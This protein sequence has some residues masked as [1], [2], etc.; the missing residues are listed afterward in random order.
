MLLN[1]A[2]VN[3]CDAAVRLLQSGR[4]VE[5]ADAFTNIVVKD[6]KVSLA[7]CNRG[8]ALLQMGDAV[9]AILNIQRAIDIE[10]GVPEF[11]M[12][13]G[14]AYYNL[15]KIDRAI[16]CYR[17]SLELK[18]SI[19]QTHMNLANAIK[20]K[21]N[22]REALKSYR[23]ATEMDP[24]DV[25]CHLNRA[26]AELALGNY[27]EGW[28]E[29]EW[30]WKSHQMPPRGLPLPEWDGSD[31]SGKSILLYGEQ[32]LGDV[33]QFIRYAEVLK[34]NYLNVKVT[35][36]VRYPIT[37]LARKVPGVDAVIAYGEEV[38]VA[39]F[40]CACALLSVPRHMQTTVDTIPWLGAYLF[41]DPARVA[42]WRQRLQ[43]LP[44]GMLVGVCWA[45]QSRPGR[46][47]CEVIDKRRSTTLSAF[48]P[49]AQIPGISWV[50]L[51]KGIPRS[52]VEKP[53]AGMTIG[54]WTDELDDF[55]DTAAL[56][57]CLDLVISVDTSVVHLAAGM[58][59]PTWLLSRWD[60]CWRW[61]DCRQD[62]P[63]Y[64]TLR[65]FVQPAPRD[66]TSMMELA[67]TE[68]R[69]RVAAF[70]LAA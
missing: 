15:E 66:W 7:W 9:D 43:A 8:L 54:D 57:E 36:E 64:P 67:A 65:Q 17:K 40:D 11:H 37:R 2:M 47:E 18:P 41:A 62:S 69:K 68:L 38:P 19:A 60:G 26:H 21:G 55:Y 12:N 30:R 59:K 70:K 34:R 4:L 61:L 39:D 53:P 52:Q 45:G 1:E 23:T 16:E 50:S 10:E 13:L 28:R 24:E 14:V 46:P 35:V 22:L 31:L 25:D 58:G 3:E 44:P 6:E 48:A 5:A 20:F 49:L 42:I 56:I 63:W 33:L 32:G 51:Q 27:E 29:F